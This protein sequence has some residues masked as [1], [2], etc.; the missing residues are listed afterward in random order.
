MPIVREH[1]GLAMSSRN[2]RL[3]ESR[4]EEAK[5]IYK[6]LTN[7]KKQF[8]SK[9]VTDIIQSVISEINSHSGF[10]VEYFEIVDGNTLMSVNN[11]SETDYAVGC[12]TVFCD[13]IRLIDNITYFLK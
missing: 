13:E 12:I 11:W 5:L 1:S 2:S 8:L 4:K 10:E 3:S 6:T 9:S 7:S